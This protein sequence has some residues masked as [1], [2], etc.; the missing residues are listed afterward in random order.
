MANLA[1]ALLSAALTAALFLLVLM[2]VEGWRRSP[3]LAAVT[4]SVIPLAA[5]AA[6]PLARAARA[7]TRAE[8]VAGSLLMAGG[9]VALALPPGAEPAWTLAPQA[10]VGLGLGLTVDSLTHVAL[11]DRVPRALHGGWTI[12]A[13]HAGVV[14]AL[15]LLT[16][17]FTADLERQEDRA[18]ESVLATLLDSELAPATKVD[19]GL[20]LATLLDT[21]E[22]E[23]P[24]VAPAFD[25]VAPAPQE[26]ATV[27]RLERR[28]GEE[29][30]RAATT[31]FERSFLI[32]AAL[33]LGA[34]LPAFLARRR[35]TA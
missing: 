5:L 31:A 13:R 1:L 28:V 26:Q 32:A 9:L 3:A 18:A 20:E 4:V 12:A 22:G 7:G 17:I 25:E 15:A 35:D 14:T 29:L 34:L 19:L 11:R 2:L 33:S 24:E 27:D 10:L 16:P 23:V 30:D 6:G 8:A 21:A